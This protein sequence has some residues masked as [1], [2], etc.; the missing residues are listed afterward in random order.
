MQKRE[1]ILIALMAIA[2]LYGALELFVFSGRSQRPADDPPAAVEVRDVKDAA[3]QAKSA[4]EQ[5][6]LSEQQRRVLEVAAAPWRPDLFYPVPEMENPP[7]E[8]AAEPATGVGL[9][10]RGYL[11]VGD[12]RMAIINGVEYR[13]G[14]TVG[15]TGYV[16]KAI[17]PDRVF[18]EA[19]GD[20][21]RVSVPY[22]E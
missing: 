3:D 12:R 16:L 6:A 8:D 19:P 4:V 18:V 22:S 1:K 14:E 2:V 10:Y 11:A 15:E 20:G 7:R 21:E 17:T 9:E 13:V 5:A